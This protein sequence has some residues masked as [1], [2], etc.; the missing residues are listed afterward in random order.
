M[1]RK[2]LQAPGNRATTGRPWTKEAE[3]ALMSTKL[4]ICLCILYYFKEHRDN[5]WVPFL[6]MYECKTLMSMMYYAFLPNNFADCFAKNT[7]YNYLINLIC[8]YLILPTNGLIKIVYTMVAFHQA[9]PLQF[10]CI[11]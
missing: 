11:L 3:I 2:M 4:L 10:C 8:T 1:D 7:K 5:E 6:L 9:H